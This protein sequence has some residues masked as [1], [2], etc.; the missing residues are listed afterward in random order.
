MVVFG[1][2]AKLKRGHVKP[3]F[4]LQIP[5]IK[6]TDDV[7]NFKIFLGSSSKAMGDRKKK[8][9]RQKYKNL[10]ILR[11]KRAFWMK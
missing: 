5:L 4:F 11:M 9:G 2:L 7:I 6:T 10:S 8:K 1:Y 3:Y